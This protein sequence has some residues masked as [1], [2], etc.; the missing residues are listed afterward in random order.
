MII[1]YEAFRS[2]IQ[3]DSNECENFL[4]NP[5]PDLVVCDEGHLLKNDKTNLSG[6]LDRIRTIRR[7]ALTGTPLQN[8]L[9]E[10]YCMVDFVKPSLLGTT[11]EFN[12]R[13]A[14][15]IANSQFKDSKPNDIAIMKRRTYVLN[16]LLEGCVQ[17]L[18]EEI[19]KPLL[20]PKMEFAVFVRLSSEQAKLYQVIG[21]TLRKIRSTKSI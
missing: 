12:N 1:G 18:D 10:Y 15:P 2:F 16:K 6:A 21:S 20:P 14:N 8:H 9:R 3:S 13:F 19:L 17:R 5:G 7:I 4:A 11:R